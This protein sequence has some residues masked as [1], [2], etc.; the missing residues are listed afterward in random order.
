MTDTC[1]HPAR[2][3]TEPCWPCENADLRAELRFA[4]AAH[5]RCFDEMWETREQL[6]AARQRIAELEHVEQTAVT[7][8]TRLATMGAVIAHDDAARILRDALEK[9]H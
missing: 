9:K 1:N 6:K 3:S 5:K 8:M 4:L 7:L 2:Y